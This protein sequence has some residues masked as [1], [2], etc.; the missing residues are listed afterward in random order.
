MTQRY[1]PS[2]TYVD[3]SMQ[4]LVSLEK[5]IS[6]IERHQLQK[7]IDESR[8]CIDERTIILRHLIPFRDSG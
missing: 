8:R 2:Y 3:D 1:R 6:L 5:L 7:A 4:W